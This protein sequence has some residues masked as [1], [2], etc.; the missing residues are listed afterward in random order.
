MISN[1]IGTE[2][3]P[4]SPPVRE[5]FR[6]PGFRIE[7]ANLEELRPAMVEDDKIIISS[8]VKRNERDLAICVE[9]ASSNFQPDESNLAIFAVHR[10]ADERHPY[11]HGL[12]QVLERVYTEI[13]GDMSLIQLYD[14]PIVSAI[15]ARLNKSKQATVFKRDRAEGLAPQTQATNIQR[16]VTIAETIITGDQLFADQVRNVYEALVPAT[17]AIQQTM[18]DKTYLID[19]WDGLGFRGLDLAA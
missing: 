16:A 5:F 1:S 6:N 14:Y 7:Y 11:E 15:A 9:L 17:V 4:Q 3:N 10:I 8:L 13:A 18:F 19:D 12:H 2:P